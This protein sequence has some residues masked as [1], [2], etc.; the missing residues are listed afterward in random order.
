VAE[1]YFWAITSG[2]ILMER[3]IKFQYAGT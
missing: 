2:G 1:E 3:P